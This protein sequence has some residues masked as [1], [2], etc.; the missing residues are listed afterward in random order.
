[1]HHNNCPSRREYQVRLTRQI[2]AVQPVTVTEAMDDGPHQH[3]WFHV[4]AFNAPHIF[5]AP[6]RRKA[7]NHF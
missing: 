5:G 4:F 7:I 3:F 2:G 6:L 1:M